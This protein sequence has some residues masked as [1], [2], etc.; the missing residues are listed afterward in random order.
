M[1]AAPRCPRKRVNSKA[2]SLQRA[3][4]LCRAPDVERRPTIWPMVVSFAVHGR[5]RARRRSSSVS[6][7]RRSAIHRPVRVPRRR[8]FPDR[9][10]KPSGHECAPRPGRWDMTAEPAAQ[11]GARTIDFRLRYDNP[12]AELG[13][14]VSTSANPA[15]EQG[16]WADCGALRR[17]SS[18]STAGSSV[19]R[20]DARR[21][22]PPGRRKGHADQ[23]STAAVLMPVRRSCPPVHCVAQVAVA[24]A[25][26]APDHDGKVAFTPPAQRAHGSFRLYPVFPRDVVRQGRHRARRC[27][28][29]PVD[30]VSPNDFSEPC[31]PR[32]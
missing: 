1:S 22:T 7:L 23:S 10:E 28:C 27:R 11:R 20:R 5:A 15:V 6:G 16:E 30:G 8:R 24:S 18:P 13:S 12:Q 14:P 29:Q 26:V 19:E 2:S 32:C 3:S 25:D 4:M 9:K 31:G 17:F 21:A